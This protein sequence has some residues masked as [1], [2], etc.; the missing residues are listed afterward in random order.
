MRAISYSVTR[1]T[2]DPHR[3]LQITAGQYCR[4]FFACPR[5]S[6]V[7]PIEGILLPPSAVRT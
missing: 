7:L 5:A 2:Q 4:L 1:K 6:G 3:S